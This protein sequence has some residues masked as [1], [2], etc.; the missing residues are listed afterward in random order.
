M[1]FCA[2]LWCDPCICRLYLHRITSIV[3]THFRAI[4]WTLTYIHDDVLSCAAAEVVWTL[5]PNARTIAA[6][7]DWMDCWGHLA[8]AAVVVV[9]RPWLHCLCINLRLQH[10]SMQLL[11]QWCLALSIIWL[12]CS[13]SWGAPSWQSCHFHQL[14]CQMCFLCHLLFPV[15]SA[16]PVWPAFPMSTAFSYGEL[17]SDVDPN[18]D[19]TAKSDSDSAWE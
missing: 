1:H 17:N 14:L 3:I 19:P 16:F 18:S 5:V 12:I 13:D 11:H 4:P 9:L 15:S 6:Q 7:L 2:C 10:L 8:Y